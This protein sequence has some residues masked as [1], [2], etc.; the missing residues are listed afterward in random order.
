MFYCYACRNSKPATH[1]HFQDFGALA[2]RPPKR[3][4]TEIEALWDTMSEEA[5]AR[6]IEEG[7]QLLAAAAIEG[8]RPPRHATS[9]A[10]RPRA[11][12]RSDA[13]AIEEAPTGEPMGGLAGVLLFGAG[14]LLGVL[15]RG[16]WE[17]AKAAH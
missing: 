3:H 5:Q 12:N 10:P 6:A 14:A 4:I 8:A 17:A 9:P 15:G 7:R 13:A 1:A 2:L 11:V 16:A